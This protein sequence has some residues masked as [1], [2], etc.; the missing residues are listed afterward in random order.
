[1]VLLGA[2]KQR[3]GLGEHI[4]RP[5]AVSIGAERGRLHFRAGIA[6]PPRFDSV[7]KG[8]QGSASHHITGPGLTTHPFHH[9]PQQGRAGL[10]V[11]RCSS[12]GSHI[13]VAA[14]ASKG[15][16]QA[17]LDATNALNPSAARG[18][19]GGGGGSYGAI[20]VCMYVCVVLASFNR[21]WSSGVVGACADRC[22]DTHTYT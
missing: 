8:R 21:G 3:V 19:N 16:F 1:M 15:G 18:G 5:G 17:A 12:L 10:A 13:M 14:T 20:E 2:K 22:M 11:L 9:L 6:A 7:G 4:G